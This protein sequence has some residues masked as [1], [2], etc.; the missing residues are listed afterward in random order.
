MFWEKIVDTGVRGVVHE[1]V[2]ESIARHGSDTW[3]IPL[4]VLAPGDD[5]AAAVNRLLA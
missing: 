1:G 3:Q 2:G 5:P 4:E